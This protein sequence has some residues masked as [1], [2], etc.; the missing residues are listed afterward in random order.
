MNVIKDY[1]NLK[2]KNSQYENQIKELKFQLFKD[3]KLNS[4][5]YKKAKDMIYE[6]EI[7]RSEFKSSIAETKEKIRYLDN[8]ILELNEMKKVMVDL[9]YNIPFKRRLKMKINKILHK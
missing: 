7:L 1:E 5:G 2:E 8:L 9:G 4:E 6:M 3:K